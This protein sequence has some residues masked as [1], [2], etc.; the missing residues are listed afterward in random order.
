MVNSRATHQWSSQHVKAINPRFIGIS[1]CTHKKKK[2]LSVLTSKVPQFIVRMLG[3][4]HYQFIMG[5][6]RGTYKIHQR[7]I[8]NKLEPRVTLKL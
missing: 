5:V 8:L 3:E 1:Y 6:C 7:L 2:Y 4:I